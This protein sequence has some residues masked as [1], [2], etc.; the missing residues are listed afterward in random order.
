MIVTTSDPKSVSIESLFAEADAVAFVKVMSGDIE[1]YNDALY[2]AATTK[3]YKGLKEKDVIYFAPFIGY[4]IRSEYLV[5]LRKTDGVIGDIVDKNSKSKM[6]PYDPAQKIHEIMYEG[7]GIMPVSFECAFQKP[8][9]STCQE[10]VQFVIS[11]VTLPKRIKTY[12]EEKPDETPSNK[13]FVKRSEIEGSL[14]SL[15]D[16]VR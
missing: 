11:Q 3:G 15:R 9:H 16:A 14:E 4:G 7:Y 6:R 2:K 8:S 13:R 1:N 10:A 5:F 12:P